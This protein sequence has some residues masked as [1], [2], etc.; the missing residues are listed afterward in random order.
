MILKDIYYKINNLNRYLRRDKPS[1]IPTFVFLLDVSSAS[2]QNGFLSA[3]LESI[4]D[5][6]NNDLIPQGDRTRVNIYL[7]ILY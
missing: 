4:K 1:C 7:N 6:I 2:I 3:C 5:A